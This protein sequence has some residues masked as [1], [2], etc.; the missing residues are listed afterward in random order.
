M[1]LFVP[2]CR[3]FQGVFAKRAKHHPS[4]SEMKRRNNELLGSPGQRART[5][6]SPPQ[7]KQQGDQLNRRNLKPRRTSV[8]NV[9]PGSRAGANRKLLNQRGPKVNP[10]NARG[11]AR[12]H[13]VAAAN[14]RRHRMHRLFIRRE[15]FEIFSEEKRFNLEYFGAIWLF[16]FL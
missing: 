13:R 12:H 6:P 4:S 14:P 10:G 7:N 16:W 5:K 9:Q 2:A 11:H 1:R 3:L 15:I 8:F